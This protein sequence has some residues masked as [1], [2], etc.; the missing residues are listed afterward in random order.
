MT[1]L[2][3]AFNMVEPISVRKSVFARGIQYNME[4]NERLR[5]AYKGENHLY[6]R[7]DDNLDKKGKL[8]KNTIG[9]C[10]VEDVEVEP[11]TP[12]KSK[13][14]KAPASKKTPSKSP[15][16]PQRTQPFRQASTGKTNAYNEGQSSTEKKRKGNNS[17]KPN[18][19]PRKRMPT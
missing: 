6:L 4:D 3:D 12:P 8:Y 14:K 1:R 18:K 10:T 15:T 7:V 19:K 11:E 17:S 16:K 2:G 5:R 9:A 13:P